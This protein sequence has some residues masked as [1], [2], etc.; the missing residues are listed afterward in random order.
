MS[1]SEPTSLLNMELQNLEGMG[2]HSLSKA[3]L[4]PSQPRQL[5]PRDGPGS[6]SLPFNLALLTNTAD[7]DNISSEA[8]QFI[9][10]LESLRFM[11]SSVLMFPSQFSMNEK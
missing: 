10:D 3:E 6:T 8:K 11:S 7:K 2:D 4:Q 1:I 9:Q 5:P